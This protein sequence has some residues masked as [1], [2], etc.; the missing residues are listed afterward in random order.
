[1]FFFNTVM[2]HHSH[3]QPP[4]LHSAHRWL[5]G[6]ARPRSHY[7]TLWGVAWRPSHRS[8][9]QWRPH[10]PPLCQS[11][12][13]LQYLYSYTKQVFGSNT[14]WSYL[15]TLHYV[16]ILYVFSIVLNDY[17]V[18]VLSFA[19]VLRKQVQLYSLMVL[20]LSYYT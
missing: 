1:M 4:P 15:F 17:F 7:A 20:L 2:V 19:N 13:T 12:H 16:V 8:P 14:W 18:V 3:W 5:T 6:A 11:T 9:R 10:A